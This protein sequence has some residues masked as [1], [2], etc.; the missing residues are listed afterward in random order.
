MVLSTEQMEDVVDELDSNKDGQVCVPA[1]CYIGVR[2][3][4]IGSASTDAC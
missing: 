3:G 2:V 4:R 1:A